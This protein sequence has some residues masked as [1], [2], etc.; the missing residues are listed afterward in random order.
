M[1]NV[2]EEKKDNKKKHKKLKIW[3]TIV[4]CALVVLLT[5]TYVTYLITHKDKNRNPNTYNEN[6]SVSL[7]E[8]NM[9]DAFSMS[10]D[11]GKFSFT[12][13]EQDIN[14]MLKNAKDHIVEDYVESI[15]YEAKDNHHYFYID[16]KS[17]LLVET[18]VVFDTSLEGLTSDNALVLQIDKVTMGKLP[19][20]NKAKYLNEEFFKSLSE[21]SLL[22]I[23]FD[24]SSKKLIVE[25]LKFMDYFPSGGYMDFLKE[26]ISLKPEIMKPSLTSLF[27][28][29]IDFTSFRSSKYVI[30]KRS[31]SIQ[32]IKEV[33]DSSITED[34]IDSL[35]YDVP[36]S[37]CTLSLANLN[38]VI[39]K[40]LNVFE[41][42]IYSSELSQNQCL[43]GFS[44]LYVIMDSNTFTYRIRFSI[45]GYDIDFDV[46]SEVVDPSNNLLLKIVTGLECK[47]N[48]LEIPHESNIREI[49]IKN[50]NKALINMVASYEYMSY[51]V[52]DLS[53]SLDFSYIFSSIPGYL[54]FEGSIIPAYT[55]EPYF[56]FVITKR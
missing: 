30:P 35:E 55:E 56:D 43:L 14:Q 34:F 28:F 48:E 25:P 31:E 8:K 27:G 47:T 42:E 21:Y 7:I 19:Y 52:G 10:K 53:L 17:K 32:N 39:S 44:D 22:P 38:G 16:L 20:L 3:L 29:E 6:L 26:L 2:E 23:K 13:P 45:N 46:T 5:A 11:T 9:I 1:D 51:V 50:L 54:V 24:N 41:K 37:A 12:L 33:V 18:R 4:S 36:T 49:V 15:Y 40:Y